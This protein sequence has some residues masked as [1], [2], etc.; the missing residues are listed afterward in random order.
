MFQA[1]NDPCWSGDV[2][3]TQDTRH[4]SGVRNR[5]FFM[6][7]QKKTPPKAGSLGFSMGVLIF[8]VGLSSVVALLNWAGFIPQPTIQIQIE[9][10]RH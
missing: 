4:G 9:Q 6:S 8:V 5:S 10:V 1:I 7:R 3:L 2:L